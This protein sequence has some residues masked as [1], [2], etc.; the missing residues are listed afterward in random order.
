VK[1]PSPPAVEVKIEKNK[2][3]VKPEVKP[4]VKSEIKPEKK[5]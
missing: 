4:E 3:E 1:E 5:V 2:V